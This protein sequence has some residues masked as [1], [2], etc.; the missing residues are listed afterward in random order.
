M[1]SPISHD[2]DHHV[3]GEEKPLSRTSKLHFKTLL[4][5]S[6]QPD[7]SSDYVTSVS[8]SEP[9]MHLRH[10]SYMPIPRSD[11]QEYYIYIYIS[12]GEN[13]W[14]IRWCTFSEKS[15]LTKKSGKK[16]TKK[17]Q[18][19]CSKGHIEDVRKIS[20]SESKKRR[21]HSPGNTVAALN[22]N[23]PVLRTTCGADFRTSCVLS[24]MQMTASNEFICFLAWPLPETALGI[25]CN[26]LVGALPH[27]HYAVSRNPL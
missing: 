8:V 11:L 2:W 14:A 23:Q 10:V 17:R 1:W 26:C 22:V 19:R 15:Y 6:S 9:A 3:A 16:Q 5:L 27:A 18:V 25:L 12:F 21:G 24:C 20:W 13:I 7:G 4:Y